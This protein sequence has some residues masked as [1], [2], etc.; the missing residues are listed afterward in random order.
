MTRLPKLIASAEEKVRAVAQQFH[1]PAVLFS[2]G[3]D[4]I[5]LLHLISQRM[6]VKTPVVLYKEPFFVGKYTFALGVLDSWGLTAYDYPPV[7]V[8][9]WHGKGIVAF[10]NHYQVGTDS[11]GRVLTLDVPKNIA[12]PQEG[13]P[14]L[15]G[16]NDILRRPLARFECPWDLFFCGHKSSDEDQIAGKV[17]LNADVNFA[18]HSPSMAFPLRDWT[19]DDVWDYIEEFN[20]PVDMDRYDATNRKEWEDKT[21]NSDYFHCCIRCIDRREGKSVICPKLGMEVMNIS[22]QVPYQESRFNYFGDD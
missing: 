4:S 6:G 20:L 17:P 16:L 19:D 22:E 3:K 1:R 8:S 14:Y 21:R 2:G 18:T 13:R 5:V 7:G 12:E 9:L 10:T 15:C 11:Q